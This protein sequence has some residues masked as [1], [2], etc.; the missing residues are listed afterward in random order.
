M[1]EH[2]TIA[3]I[4]LKR[5]AA[6]K[7]AGTA[8]I[9]PLQ[10]ARSEKLADSGFFSATD[11]DAMSFD[12]LKFV[13]PGLIVEGLT[14][15]CGKPKIGKSWLLLHAAIAIARGGFTL[16]DQVHRGRCPMLRPGRQQA[17]PPKPDEEAARRGGEQSSAEAYL[18]H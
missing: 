14:L 4:R 3:A 5:A 2:P 7:P 16:G 9:L 8:T 10:A 12:P 17:A 18:P 11:L 13:I 15:F 6:S 1:T